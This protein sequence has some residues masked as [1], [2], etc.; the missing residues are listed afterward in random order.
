[1]A[2]KK[3]T[4]KKTHSIRYYIV[5][6]LIVSLLVFVPIGIA[7]MLIIPAR[8]FQIGGTLVSRVK[9]DEKVVAL[10]FD[11]GPSPV[12]TDALIKTLRSSDVPATFFLIGKEIERHPTETK[13]L[14]D[15]GFEIGNH[16]YRHDSLVF[17]S[18]SSIAREIEKTDELIRAQGYKGVI[19]VR[20][21]Y[22]HKLIGL[23][24]YLA[25]HDRVTTMWNIAPDKNSSTQLPQS[26]V[27]NV[28]DVIVPGS[29]IILHAMYDHNQPSRDALAQIIVELRSHGYRFI[30]VS[31]LLEYR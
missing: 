15:A 14:I 5:Q 4:K 1:M 20:P 23:P 18:S 3:K 29:I 11:D 26:I 27:E 30:T 19:P 25:S 17:K 9:T 31:Q 6:N 10:T 8:T 2:V 21:P 13:K 16:S 22:G 7:V 24:R 12:H 28:T